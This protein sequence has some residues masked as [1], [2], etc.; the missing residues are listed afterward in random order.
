MR[1]RLAVAL[2]L[3]RRG[4]FD[5]FVLLNALEI[6]RCLVGC[7]SVVDVGCGNASPLQDIKPGKAIGI[8]GYQPSLETARLNG[9]HTEFI[10]GDIRQLSTLC[11]PGQYHACIALDVIEHLPKTDGY[12][13]IRD[14]ELIASRRVVFLTPNGFLPQR[15]RERD[16]LQEHLSGWT[17][18]EMRELG[19]SAIGLLGPKSLRGEF[20]QLKRSPKW[21]WFLV[22]LVWHFVRTRGVPQEA[23]AILC[24]KDKSRDA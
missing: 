1:G 23:A 24:W 6:R 17:A 10:L 15:H 21:F 5:P 7:E 3:W 14:M 19:Y 20:H 16:D 2:N 9:T 13:L 8:D 12:K 4:I 11:T 22:A 18:D